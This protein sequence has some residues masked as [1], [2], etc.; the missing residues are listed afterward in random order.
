VDEFEN[1]AQCF[2]EQYSE[3]SIESPSGEKIHVNGKLTLGENIA[4]AG[5]LNAAFNA[6]KKREAENPGQELPGLQELTKE[7]LFFVSFGRVWCGKSRK[8]AA[9]DRIR[10]DPHSPTWARVLGTVANAPGFSEAFNCPVR[11]PR[12]EL[13]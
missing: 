10:T 5:G 7:Q 9:V 11:K 3:F 8:E 4:D 2:V 13:W 12:C 1:R 6:W